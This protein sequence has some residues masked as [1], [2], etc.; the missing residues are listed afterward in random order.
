MKTIFTVIKGKLTKV[1]LATIIMGMTFIQAE[2]VPAFTQ[3]A[4][5]PINWV[6]VAG[7]IGS[8]WGTIRPISPI[9]RN[10]K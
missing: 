7:A 4:S 8:L 10:H 2:I 9:Y 1:S 3:A 6:M 5:V